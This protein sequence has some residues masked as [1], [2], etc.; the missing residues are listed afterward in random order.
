MASND[1]TM[2]HNTKSRSNM[3]GWRERP[4]RGQF[5]AICVRVR[6]E[7]VHSQISFSDIIRRNLSKALVTI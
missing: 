4:L 5:D 1:L 3:P 6:N 7:I 2:Y